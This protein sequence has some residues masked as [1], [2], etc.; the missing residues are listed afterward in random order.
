MISTASKMPVPQTGK[1]HSSAKAKF[2]F[3]TGFNASTIR[4]T[5]NRNHVDDNMTVALLFEPDTI[6]SAQYFDNYQRKTAKE[7]ETRLLLAVL[8]D[9]VHCFQDNVLAENGKSKKLFDDAEQWFLEESGEWIF[10]FSNV[11]EL[12]GIDPEYLRAGLM[13]WKQKHVTSAKVRLQDIDKLRWRNSQ[14]K[15][16][17]RG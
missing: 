2:A 7:P 9:A 16:A 13:H 12:L 4:P 3:H 6:A 15:M 1:E 11:C 10:S 8:E 17:S 5:G 14:S